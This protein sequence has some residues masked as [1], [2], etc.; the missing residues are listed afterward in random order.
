M[1][2]ARARHAAG[3]SSGPES[4][5]ERDQRLVAAA[6]A[7]DV[8]AFEELY[9]LYRDWVFA[10]AMRNVGNRADAED[11]L[12][13]TFS[14]LVSK[15]PDLYLAGRMTTFL[16]PV[17]VHLASRAR[18]RRARFRD[19]GEALDTLTSRPEP[20]PAD[21]A[22]LAKVLS[23]LP[24]AQR[25]VLLMRSVDGLSIAE[26]AEALEVPEGTV[27]SR[28]HHALQWLREDDRTRSYFES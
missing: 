22:E 27:K 25:E 7:G 24:E 8:S 26:I 5:F 23:G 19:P 21:R 13:E 4:A 12:Q 3:V 17:V 18:Q 28:L 11:V 14:Y 2:L 10:L 1:S 20:Q 9:R 16:Y 6:N 15:P